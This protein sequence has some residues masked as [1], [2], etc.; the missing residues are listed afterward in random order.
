MDRYITIDS[1]PTMNIILFHANESDGETLVVEGDRAK[2]IAKILRLSVGDT[3]RVG[4][5]NGAIGRGKIQTINKKQPYQAKIRFLLEQQPAEPAAIDLI[6]ALP[7]P[8]MFKRIL[9]QGTSLGIKNF[10]IINAARVEKS[11]WDSQ[12]L[13][14]DS[15]NYHLLKGLEQAVDTIMPQVYFH[16]SFKAFLDNMLGKLKPKYNTLVIA[17][18]SYD[19]ISGKLIDTGRDKTL[20]AIGPEGGW[21]DFELKRMQEEGFKGMS[22]GPRILRV[23]TAVI[24]LHALLT[25]LRKSFSGHSTE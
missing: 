11:F 8:I 22:L 25:G 6:L 5:V 12:V 24:A 2:H 4:M 9:S 14:P 20:L 3:V 18:P 23:D 19:H 16:R 1:E 17:D 10:H 13:N 7:R 15:Y 21:I